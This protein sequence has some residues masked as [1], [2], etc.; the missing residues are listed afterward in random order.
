MCKRPNK[1]LNI[2][3][4]IFFRLGSNGDGLIM[5]EGYDSYPFALHAVSEVL[6]NERRF[7]YHLE[8]RRKTK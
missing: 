1:K 8:L 7:W 3:F 4:L 5:V 6:E 2:E